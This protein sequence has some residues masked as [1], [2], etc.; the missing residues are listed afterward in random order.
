MATLEAHLRQTAVK[1]EWLRLE[2]AF[3][4]VAP[5]VRFPVPAWMALSTSA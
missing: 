3:I 2:S 1:M 5:T 4:A